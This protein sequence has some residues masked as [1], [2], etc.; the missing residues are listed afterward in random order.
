MTHITHSSGKLRTPIATEG[1]P[2]EASEGYPRNSVPAAPP[3]TPL[4]PMAPADS[5]PRVDPGAPPSTGGVRLGQTTPVQTR[6]YIVLVPRGADT[7]SAQ[8]MQQMIEPMLARPSYS[9]RQQALGN[10]E[11]GRYVMTLSPQEVQRMQSE[12]M[13]VIPNATVTIP[14]PLG[15][16]EVDETFLTDEITAED[17]VSR[18]VHQVERLQQRQ[19]FDGSGTLAITADTGIT[20]DN[21]DIRPT[22]LFDD[23]ATPSP[24][25]PQRDTSDHGSHVHSISTARGDNVTGKRGVAPEASGG[26]IIALPGGGGSIAQVLASIETA[27]EWS[28]RPEW[29][30]RFVS[31]N[32]SLGGPTTGDRAND[33]LAQAVQEAEEVHGIYVT[34]A[35]GNSGPGLGTVRSPAWGP[36]GLAVAATDHAGSLD[37]EDD[38]IAPFSSRGTPDPGAPLGQRENPDAAAGGVNIRG[39]VPGGYANLSGTSMA[40]PQH[41]GA[42]NVLGGEVY[43]MLQDGV[44][45]R[46]AV[47]LV[48]DRGETVELPEDWTVRDLVRARVLHGWVTRTSFDLVD[49]APW[50]DGAG[51]LRLEDAANLMLQELNVTEEQRVAARIANEIGTSGNED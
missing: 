11:R 21:P 36:A 9:E 32:L 10:P 13:E 48:N 37:T 25:D 46:S 1:A 18:G 27:I 5:A 7:I 14:D 12:G 34:I 30:D 8:S 31:L 2:A 6:E 23:P 22:V 20:N 51:D 3:P 41:A 33:L 49:E 44:I 26:G 19:G 24:T 4:A 17:I 50:E 47:Q 29:A 40:A 42:G 43:A 45:D 16:D 28:N 15:G 39:V 35:N 38:S